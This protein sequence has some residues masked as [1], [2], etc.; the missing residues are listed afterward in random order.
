MYV[1]ET[2]Y[3]HATYGHHGE[4]AGRR[5]TPPFQ[6][7]LTPVPHSPVERDTLVVRVQSSTSHVSKVPQSEPLSQLLCHQSPMRLQRD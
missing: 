7:L 5:L 2:N 6:Q 3:K 1:A 4:L